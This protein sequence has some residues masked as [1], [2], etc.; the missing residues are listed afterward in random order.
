MS[1]LLKR[2]QQASRMLS[3]AVEPE[4]AERLL[5]FELRR[6]CRADLVLLFR[7][8]APQHWAVTQSHPEELLA[9]AAKPT[10]IIWGRAGDIV[11]LRPALAQ[12]LQQRQGLCCVDPLRAGEFDFSYLRP[13]EVDREQCV[14][15]S[16]LLPLAGRD[17]RAELMVE[18][19]RLDKGEFPAA[20]S[21]DEF[22]AA[23][24]L[25]QQAETGLLRI[26]CH[27]ESSELFESLI[28]LIGSAI[29]EKSPFAGDHCRRV[30]V[31]TM[32]LA[33]AVARSE[34]AAFKAVRFNDAELYELEVAAWLHDIGK[35]ITPIHI[36]DKATKLERTI[37]RFDLV[38]TRFEILR[39]DLEI[40]RLRVGEDSA[41]VQIPAPSIDMVQMLDD[42]RFLAD[43]NRGRN[44]L[45]PE[46]MDRVRE[47][48][49][50]Y[51]WVDRQGEEMP[52]ISDDEASN[53]M[54]LRGPI[55]DAEREMINHH[56]V[57]TINMLD[58]LPFP[59][60]LSQVPEIAGSHHEYHNGRGFPS[61]L[62]GDQMLIQARI[63]GFADLFESVSA[64]SRPYKSRNS[65]N[66]ALQIMR[67]MVD[68]GQVDPDLY[69][70]FVEEK[71]YESY[72][73]EFLS[74]DQIDPVDCNTLLEGL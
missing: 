18:L 60:E 25:A 5:L 37:D 6:L 14:I 23:S 4:A 13:I 41:D 49:Q 58:M 53:L 62:S 59:Q 46:E 39:R 11:G 32:M 3:S 16:M 61:G 70:L 67:G 57:S 24:I 21:A 2:L 51:H 22:A 31:L 27:R 19:L 43:C 54:V 38:R 55:T 26:Y 34:Q 69:R 63:L 65:L 72:A 48:S 68:A 64:G 20:F 12:V 28:Q 29:D 40:V 1:S 15:A 10:E 73:V 66:Q 33:R 30:P 35:L 71:L 7:P 47:I 44:A 8:Q 42:L 74:R 9:S 17:G 56:V 45:F 50:R 36:T 52:V